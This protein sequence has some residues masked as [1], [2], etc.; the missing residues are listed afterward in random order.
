MLQFPATFL[1][2]LVGFEAVGVLAFLVS[3]EIRRFH[4]KINLEANDAFAVVMATG[5]VVAAVP[6][7]GKC[8]G[9]PE[10]CA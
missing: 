1:W 3:C 5:A 9:L 4:W 10:I 8:L 6:V 7:S 2:K